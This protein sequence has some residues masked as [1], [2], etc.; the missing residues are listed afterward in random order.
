MALVLSPV[1]GTPFPWVPAQGGCWGRFCCRLGGSTV[2][3]AAGFSQPHR[4]EPG[5]LAG[6]LLLVTAEL[7]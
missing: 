3:G 6:T 1:Q 4:R 7:A 5:C 2:P